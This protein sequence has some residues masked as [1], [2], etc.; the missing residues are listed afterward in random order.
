[1]IFESKAIKNIKCPLKFWFIIFN[2]CNKNCP[3][4]RRTENGYFY[5]G[6]GGSPYSI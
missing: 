6:L 3:C 5:C 2:K 1:M 4:L